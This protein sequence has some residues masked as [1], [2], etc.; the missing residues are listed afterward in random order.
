VESAPTEKLFASPKH[1]YTEALLSAVPKPDPRLRSERIILQGEVAD[2]AST[3][4][5]CHFH[6][7]CQY[8]QAVCRQK[9]PVL[10]EIAADH[11]VSCHRAAELSLRGVTG[12]SVSFARPDGS[13]GANTKPSL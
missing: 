13:L 5:G 2:P 8:A 3:P 7:R 12:S 11:F 1:P 4:P 9:S 10:Q 6:P